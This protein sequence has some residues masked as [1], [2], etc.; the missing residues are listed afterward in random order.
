MFFLHPSPPLSLALSPPLKIIGKSNTGNQLLNTWLDGGMMQ[1]SLSM[2]LI[3]LI[4]NWSDAIVAGGKS[5]NIP[6][7]AQTLNRWKSPNLK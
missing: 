7:T 3:P 5:F 6:V 1:I 4:T 2:H